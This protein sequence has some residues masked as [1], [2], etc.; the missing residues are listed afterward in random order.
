MFHSK[1]GGAGP[2][3]EPDLVIDMVD[4]MLDG[5]GREIELHC[6]ISI[7]EAAGQESQHLHL[8]LAKT[9]RP[10]SAGAGDMVPGLGQHG[11]HGVS[12]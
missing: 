10:R 9:T 1:Q 12:I 3:G 2:G 7:G 6:H 5:V 4:V 8:P 11:M